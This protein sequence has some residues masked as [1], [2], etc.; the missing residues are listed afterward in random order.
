MELAVVRAGH[1]RAE[2]DTIALCDEFIERDME[3]REC[4]EEVEASLS[5]S[6]RG[7]LVGEVIA[8]RVQISTVDDLG[9]VA[10]DPSIAPRAHR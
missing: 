10:T 5:H 8:D 9:V 3:I 1:R 4:L 2:E 6:T 7:P